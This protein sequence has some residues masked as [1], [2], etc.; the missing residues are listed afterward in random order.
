MTS[1][2]ALPI[3]DKRDHYVKSIRNNL[4]EIQSRI[5]YIRQDAS[6]LFEEGKESM[7]VRRA[8]GYLTCEGGDLFNL[9]EA[10][11]TCYESISG[12]E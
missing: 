6:K 2:S 3:R 9:E 4:D 1:T 11:D 8:C 12:V 7:D 10:L 5:E